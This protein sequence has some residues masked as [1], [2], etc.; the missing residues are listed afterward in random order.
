M[1]ILSSSSSDRDEIGI[2][3]SIGPR[4]SFLEK[5]TEVAGGRYRGS[6][7]AQSLASKGET[8][9]GMISDAGFQ[10]VEYENLVGGV[11]VESGS[12]SANVNVSSSEANN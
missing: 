3:I 5:E 9:A 2:S 1:R 4:T 10:K 6:G 11:P 8:F 12:L 7:T